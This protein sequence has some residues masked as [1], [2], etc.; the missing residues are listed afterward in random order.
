MFVFSILFLIHQKFIQLRRHDRITF[1]LRMVDFSSLRDNHFDLA[2]STEIF[3]RILC[4]DDEV[5]TFSRLDRSGFG[6]DSCHLGGAGGCG[7]LFFEDFPHLL[8]NFF[9][10]INRYAVYDFKI[11]LL[12]FSTVFRFILSGS[13]FVMVFVPCFAD[14]IDI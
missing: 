5:C 10:F 3:E 7:C 14:Q 6:S 9:D 13:F 11:D 4:G 2:Q 12:F 1:Y 8:Y